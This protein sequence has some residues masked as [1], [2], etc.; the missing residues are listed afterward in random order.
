MHVNVEFTTEARDEMVRLLESRMPQ[1]ADALVTA[2]IYSEDI[3]RTFEMHGGPPPAATLRR[4]TNRE[5]MW[6]LY[7]DGVWVGFT[8]ATRLTWLRRQTERTIRVIAVA[9]QPGVP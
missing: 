9:E 7:A 1:P 5:E 6:W 2:I 8:M 4:Y 3:V